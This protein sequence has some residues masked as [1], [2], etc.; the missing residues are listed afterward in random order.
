M[1]VVLTSFSNADKAAVAKHVDWMRGEIITPISLD[2]T[3]PDAGY[4]TITVNGSVFK[5]QNDSS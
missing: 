4:V 3:L 1:K 2:A 5:N